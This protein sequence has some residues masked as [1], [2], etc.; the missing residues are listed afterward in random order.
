M[1]TG[2]SFPMV[3]WQGHEAY[4]SFSTSAEVKKNV[5]LYIH[6]FMRLHGAVLN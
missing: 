3:K 6:S 1:G 5:D 4:N 2:R